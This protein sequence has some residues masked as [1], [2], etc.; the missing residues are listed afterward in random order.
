MIDD[1]RKR[2]A[3]TAK[4]WRA[5]NPE[6]ARL[7]TRR[8]REKHPEKVA[9]ANKKKR[10]R[11]YNPGQRREWRFRRLQ[12]PEY[13]AKINAQMNARMTAIRRWMDELKISKGCI[14]CGFNAH[15]HAL[16]FDHVSGKKEFNVCNA[17]SIAQA[18]REILKCEVRC[19]NCHS[20][21]THDRR[22]ARKFAGK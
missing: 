7:A 19:A 1:K 13:K 8:W 3:E 5:N 14:D 22:Q 6:A 12:D 9:A 18:Q 21:R 4:R 15:P 20:I 11:P 2:S 17:K 16:H 10:V